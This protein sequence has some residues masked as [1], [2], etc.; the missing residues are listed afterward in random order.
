MSPRIA[1]VDTGTVF[2]GLLMQA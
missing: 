1:V 2:I